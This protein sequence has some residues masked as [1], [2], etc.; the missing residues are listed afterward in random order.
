M[1]TT[2]E[3]NELYAYVDKL[4]EDQDKNFKKMSR[5]NQVIG[6]GIVKTLAE[7]AKELKE[8]VT[9]YASDM[10]KNF[11]KMSKENQVIAR[12]AVKAINKHTSEEAKKAVNKINDHTDEAVKKIDQ[13]L[14]G[15]YIIIA[16]VVSIL[17]G[18]FTRIWLLKL[19]NNGYDRLRTA[20][21]GANGKYVYTAGL[22]DA[23]GNVLTY[24]ASTE[25]DMFKIWAFTILG[26]LVLFFVLISIRA[27]IK[28][29]KKS[30]GGDKDER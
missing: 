5:E 14:E 29:T 6:A 18:F 19:A 3:K 27:I 22:T 4:A 15:L 1:M 8:M 23:N 28:S 25:P 30:E 24:E 10:D 11:K 16:A 2:K 9:G 20:I 17:G 21:I 26:A 7:K 12:G 13:W